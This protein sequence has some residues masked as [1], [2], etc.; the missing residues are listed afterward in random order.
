MPRSVRANASSNVRQPSEQ[1]KGGELDPSHRVLDVVAEDP[2]EEHV[3]DYVEPASVHEH[4]RQQGQVGG[5]FVDLFRLH[6]RAAGTLALTHDVLSS[7][8]RLNLDDRQ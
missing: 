1:V 5:R 7:Y 2:Q 4:G 8:P 3:E 6:D